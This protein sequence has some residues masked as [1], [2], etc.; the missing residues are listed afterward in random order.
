MN[1]KYTLTAV[2]YLV[3]ILLGLTLAA[4]GPTLLKLAEHTASEIDEISLIFFF[5]ALGYLAGSY[6]SGVLYDR[7]PGHQLM[8]AMLVLLGIFIIFVPLATSLVVLIGIVLVLGFAKGALDVG[9]NTLLLWLH[10][11]KVGPFM[12]GLHAFFGLGAAIAPLIVAR[13]LDATGDVHWAFWIFSIMAFP[14]AF[15]VW[16]LPSPQPRPVP[17]EHRETGVPMLPIAIMVLCFVLYVGAEVS[18]GNWIYAYAVKLG[19]YTEITANSLN[20]AFWGFFTV[21]RLLAIWIST[22][23]RPLTILYLDFVG[24]ILSMVLIVLFRDSATMLRVGSI[25]LGLSFASIFPT[26]ITLS[27]ERM[28]VTGT[29][30][31]WFLVGGSIGGMIVPVLIGQAFDRF[32]PTSM[33]RIVFVTILLNLMSLVLFTRVS[34]KAPLAGDKIPAEI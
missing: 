16:R 31:G 30:T 33:S 20:S 28:H 2:Y 11:E 18:Y 9:G 21:G 15:L 4:E 10:N 17:A 3:F 25:L 32:G 26:F 8:S 1:Q 12:N 14:I 6:T 24:C 19:L 22:R 27:E 7:L 5:G 13:V 29:I 23:L 34:I